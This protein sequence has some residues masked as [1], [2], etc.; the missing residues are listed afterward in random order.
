MLTV[1]AGFDRVRWLPR[2]CVWGCSV[3]VNRCASKQQKHVQIPH[4]NRPH[5]FTNH[6]VSKLFGTSFYNFYKQYFLE[7]RV[8]EQ[9][10]RICS[11]YARTCTYMPA[12]AHTRPVYAAEACILRWKVQTGCFWAA[13]KKL[14]SQIM[15]FTVIFITAV[16]LHRYRLNWIS[17]IFMHVFSYCGLRRCR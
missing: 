10:Y 14:P 11:V 8:T 2:A 13:C 6:Y 17:E 5:L 16:C 3:S 1:I 15:V 9:I 12:K 7:K 4:V